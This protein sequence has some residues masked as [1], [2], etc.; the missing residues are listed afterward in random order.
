MSASDTIFAP[1]TGAGRAGIAV[2]RISGAKARSALAAMTGR[3]TWV[4]R[5][6]TCVRLRTSEGVPLDHALGFWFPAPSSFT[7]EDVGE[8]HVHGG[9]AVSAAVLAALDG[10]DGLRPAE[11]GEFSRRAFQN[12]KFDLTQ[13][14]ALADLVAAETAAQHRQALRQLDGELGRLYDGWRRQ[15]IAAMARLEAEIDFSDEDLPAALQIA[16]QGEV[17]AL[18]LEIERHLA[19]GQRGQR[20]R[21]GFAVVLIGPPNAGKSSL[22]NGLA[23]REAAIVDAAPGTTRDV[24]EVTMDIAGLAV[25][26]ADTAGLRQGKGR[27]EQEGVRRAR[28][29]A[30]AADL[31]VVVLDGAV[32]P[33][34]DDITLSM[35]DDDALIVIN[36]CDLGG[37]GD[38]L[39]VGDRPAMPVSAL[40]GNGLGELIGEIGKRLTERFGDDAAPAPTRA[41]HR[42]SLEACA[43]ALARAE[44]P[45]ASELMAEELRAAAAAL[46][47]IVGRVD[48]EDVLDVVFRE[49]CIGK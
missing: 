32:W 6:A 24:V 26:I 37:L 35:L 42:R 28:Q 18:R 20:I 7:G 43:A 44:R 23:G 39:A 15:A 19:D 31:R 48:V 27:V 49:F 14:E 36:K 5:H 45:Q 30:A 11:A 12:G 38:E 16:V 8:L 29:R 17:A 22:L 46:G 34:V 47:R 25:V 33:E 13:A 1:A 2:I 3:H 9:R 10:I 4:P 21:D 41:R 40:L